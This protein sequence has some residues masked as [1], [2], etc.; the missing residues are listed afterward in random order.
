[1][2]DNRT[3]GELTEHM[4]KENESNIKQ[5]AKFCPMINNHCRPDC[6]CFI[7]ARTKRVSYSNNSHNWQLQVAY[8]SN[9]LFDRDAVMDLA[10]REC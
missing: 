8:C 1:M 3:A 4:N 6:E 10:N 2:E 7:K 9:V 5:C